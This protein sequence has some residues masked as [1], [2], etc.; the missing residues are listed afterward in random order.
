MELVLHDTV[1]ACVYALFADEYSLDVE[2]YFS[3]IT[4]P[5]DK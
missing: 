1:P 5:A 2:R 4:A 3:P